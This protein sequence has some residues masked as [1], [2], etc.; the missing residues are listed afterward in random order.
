MTGAARVLL[1]AG[2]LVL[3]DTS[4][5][6]YL[7]ACHRMHEILTT[8]PC[9]FS[10]VDRVHSEAQ[11]VW[12]SELSGDASET[13]VIDLGAWLDAG[14]LRLLSAASEVELATYIELSLTLGSGEAMTIAIALHA[15]GAVATDDRVAVR[16]IATRVPVISSLD[17][18]KT[19]VDEVGLPPG[20]VTQ[21]LRDVRQRGRYVPS[22][23]HPLRAWWDA[24]YEP[25]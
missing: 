18:I 16:I 24:H 11:F 23:S 8:L 5:V 25:T 3:L 19:W 6:I 9:S 13:E 22:R 20:D 12:S 2:S 17:I 14:I 10:I 4:T 15:G 7:Y 1:N 21:V